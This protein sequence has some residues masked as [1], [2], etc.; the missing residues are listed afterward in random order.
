AAEAS[1]YDGMQQRSPEPRN[2][3]HKEKEA[4]VDDAHLA[5]IVEWAPRD[6][7]DV[8]AGLA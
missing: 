7:M 3:M 8:M 2:L 5:H 6:Q 4:M 1:S